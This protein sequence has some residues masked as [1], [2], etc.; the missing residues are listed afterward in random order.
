MVA[1]SSRNVSFKGIVV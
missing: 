1:K